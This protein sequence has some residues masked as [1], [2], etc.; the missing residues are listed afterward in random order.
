MFKKRKF[1]RELSDDPMDKLIIAIYKQAVTDLIA[2]RGVSKQ[3]RESAR[4]F[5]ESTETGEKCLR[6]LEKEGLY[7]GKKK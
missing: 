1:I 7:N 4:L 3:D 5:L 6:I 2:V